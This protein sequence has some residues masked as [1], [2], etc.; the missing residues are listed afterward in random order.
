MFI[1]QTTRLIFSD[2]G[3]S[4]IHF[5]V[6]NLHACIITYHFNKLKSAEMFQ[7]KILNINRIS[8]RVESQTTTWEKLKEWIKN[9]N[10]L[11]NYVTRSSNWLN[12]GTI[13]DPLWGN[14][15]FTKTC[16]KYVLVNLTFDTSQMG[17]DFPLL[18]PIQ[19]THNIH[20]SK[21]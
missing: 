21:K 13:R 6:S 2:Q 15:K 3:Q 16:V 17:M 18:Y 9:N 11:K 12:E 5:T 20:N 10:K 8:W 7:Q 4:C 1:F 14:E 19:C